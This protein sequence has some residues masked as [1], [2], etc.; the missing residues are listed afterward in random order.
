MYNAQRGGMLK[1]LHQASSHTVIVAISCPR[2]EK[3]GKRNK[4][5]KI[6]RFK[7][8]NFMES[9]KKYVLKIFRAK[10]NGEAAL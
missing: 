9:V 6:K 2:E 10:E 4:K 3:V 1:L 5:A 8:L 7:V